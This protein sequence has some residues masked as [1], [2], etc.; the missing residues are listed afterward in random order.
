MPFP[1]IE[2]ILYSLVL[3]VCLFVLALLLNR[4]KPVYHVK[5][6][7]LLKKLQWRLEHGRKV[8]ED[9]I[10]EELKKIEVKKQI[11]DEMYNSAF[12][13]VG[14]VF[15]VTLA[16]LLCVTIMNNSKGFINNLYANIYE[17]KE[18]YGS[19]YR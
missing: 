19:G 1:I 6:L 17:N 7:K 11:A 16:V 12:K 18:C 10:P 3:M 15:I 9:D 8:A 2:V 4:L 14:T 13:I 5:E